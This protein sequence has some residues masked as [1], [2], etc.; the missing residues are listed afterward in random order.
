[1]KYNEIQWNTMQYN[2]IVIKYNDIQ[3]NSNEI[4]WNTM[5]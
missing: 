5:K 4:P 2:E 1:M 3:W